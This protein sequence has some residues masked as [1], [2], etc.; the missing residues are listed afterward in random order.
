MASITING[1]NIQ[2]SGVRAKGDI[3]IRDGTVTVDGVQVAS[4]LAGQVHVKW[5]GP[6]ATLR[7]DGS[8]DCGDVAGSVNAGSSV[9]CGSVGADVDAGSSVVVSGSVQGNVDAGSSVTVGGK[10]GGSIDAGGS[11]R[12]G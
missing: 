6:L 5:D 11:V 12:T 8:V 10:V 9:R 7:A 4:G 3:V 2:I 1:S